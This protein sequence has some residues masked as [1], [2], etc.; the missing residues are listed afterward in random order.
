[1][2]QLWR[3]VA[4]LALVMGLAWRAAAA[5]MPPVDKLRE[6]M[7]APSAEVTVL[8][9]HLFEGGGDAR[10]VYLGYPAGD[11]LAALFGPDWRAGAEAV[12]F[13]ALDGYVARIGIDRL[14]EYAAFLAHARA[15]GA[16][17]VVDNIGQNQRNVP[18]GPYYLVWDNI[19]EPDLVRDGA[20]GWPYQ[21]AEIALVRRSDALPDV[22]GL[23]AAA[24]LTRE[25]CL[26]CH[27]I[28]GVGGNKFEGNLARMA[29]AWDEEDFMA[30]VLTP[31]TER[32][33]ST[34]PALPTT[35]PEAERRAIARA[36]L[37]Y[38]SAVP[39]TH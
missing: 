28:N 15:D 21:I 36:I 6:L 22:P 24:A 26:V 25:H 34:M 37:E 17:F 16:P 35:L 7:G 29:R 20:T 38:L 3:T 30:L 27:Q 11:V 32:E 1:M 31:A 19:A 39:V 14:A 13:R 5:P 23:E 2:N 9:P 18:L 4:L 33:G 10:T 12:E 8:E